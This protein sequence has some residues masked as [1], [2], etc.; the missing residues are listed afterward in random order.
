MGIA[1]AAVQMKAFN[2]E[3]KR[4]REEQD[5]ILK[6]AKK[7]DSIQGSGGINAQ[8][9]LQGGQLQGAGA[10]AL[11]GDPGGLKALLRSAF[12]AIAGAG[13]DSVLASTGGGG[14]AG[15]NATAS[16][17]RS[18]PGIRGPA[19]RRRNPFAGQTKPGVV[20][21]GTN[22]AFLLLQKIIDE[23]QGQRRDNNLRSASTRSSR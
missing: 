9:A 14:G 10:T 23:L 22:E 2:Q 16:S 13:G 18:A 20:T 12:R 1:A 15:V 3:L 19:E 6:N 17:S 8:N 4:A 5:K 21:A 11:P 7:L